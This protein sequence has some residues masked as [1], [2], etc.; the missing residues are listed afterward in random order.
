MGAFVKELGE[1]RGLCVLAGDDEVEE[2]L[3][4]AAEVAGVRNKWEMLM[5]LNENLG[6]PLRGI[7]KGKRR[8]HTGHFVFIFK[9]EFE[10]GS[11]YITLFLKRK[12]Y[13]STF[14][15][16]VKTLTKNVSLEKKALATTF[17]YLR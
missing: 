8:V 16:S 1:R 12:A 10:M 17:F 5:L 15:P 14:L 7:L 6:K 2:M 4:K 13:Q 3:G 11:A 9:G